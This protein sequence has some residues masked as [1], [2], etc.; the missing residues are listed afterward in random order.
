MFSEGLDFADLS[1]TLSKESI[2][3]R[4]SLEVRRD[5]KE[6][7]GWKP[8]GPVSWPVVSAPHL[9]QGPASSVCWSGQSPSAVLRGLVPRPGDEPLTGHPPLSSLLALVLR[10]QLT[11]MSR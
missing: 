4:P 7:W 11:L 10:G 6:E 1:L 8:G 9:P 5:R 2:A 3:H